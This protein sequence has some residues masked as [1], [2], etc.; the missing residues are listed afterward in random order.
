MGW[1]LQTFSAATPT[2]YA[3]G[4]GLRM[5]SVVRSTASTGSCA[6][7]VLCLAFVSSATSRKLAKIRSNP[8]YGICCRTRNQSLR[9]ILTS[10]LWPWTLSLSWPFSWPVSSAKLVGQHFSSS[11]PQTLKITV[12]NLCGN[13]TQNIVD[14]DK[15]LGIFWCQHPLGKC[16]APERTPQYSFHPCCTSCPPDSN[17]QSDLR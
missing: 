13:G 9:S 12:R 4:A 3:S 2:S 1:D 8:D 5:L 10:L 7:V 16:L 14:Q 17:I 6:I 11:L 15:S